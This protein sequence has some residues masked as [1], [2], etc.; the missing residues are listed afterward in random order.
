[1]LIG[2][3]A[4][5]VGVSIVSQANAQI[6]PR[7]I[8]LVAGNDFHLIRTGSYV[9]RYDSKTGTT[10]RL[11]TG[12]SGNSVKWSWD[13]LLDQTNPPA[14]EAGKYEV[15]EGTGSSGILVRID[16]QSGKTWAAV[17]GNILHWEEVSPK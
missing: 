5:V 3:A 1:M 9:Y 14:G 8:N 13:S 12:S 10:Q 4:A 7:P 6:R 15:V 11:T 16:T 2:A 17:L